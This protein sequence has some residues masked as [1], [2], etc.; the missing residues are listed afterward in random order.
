MSARS[1]HYIRMHECSVGPDHFALVSFTLVVQIRLYFGSDGNRWYCCNKQRHTSY[2]C[3]GA[4]HVYDAYLGKCC[5]SRIGN[6]LSL[7]HEF[8]INEGV[9]ACRSAPPKFN[10]FYFYG[11]NVRGE[12]YKWQIYVPVGILY[13]IQWKK[14]FSQD[15]RAETRNRRLFGP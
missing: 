5:G 15:L 9:W 1:V 3:S 8:Y 12:I 11:I 2:T 14:S 7:R 6:R 4:L 13:C 10:L